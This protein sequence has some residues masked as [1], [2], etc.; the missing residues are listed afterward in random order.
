M[1]SSEWASEIAKE[2]GPFYGDKKLGMNEC[3]LRNVPYGIQMS[4]TTQRPSRH[5]EAPYP[6]EISKNQ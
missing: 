2:E 6:L 1:L 4:Q 5:Y 3:T